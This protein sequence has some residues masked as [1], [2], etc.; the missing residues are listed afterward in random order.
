MLDVKR[1]ENN[2]FSL[3]FQLSINTK[4]TSL[5]CVAEEKGGQ[6]MVVELPTQFLRWNYFSRRE[7]IKAFIEGRH[8]QD[9]NLFLLE[10]TRHN[11]ALCTA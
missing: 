4:S 11:P 2:P 6:S 1:S 9:M 3:R 10:S 8:E 7:S 5:I